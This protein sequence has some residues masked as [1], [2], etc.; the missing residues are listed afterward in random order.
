MATE[1]KDTIRFPINLIFTML[2]CLKS[3]RNVKALLAPFLSAFTSLLQTK[4]MNKPMFCPALLMSVTEETG[5]RSNC[6][7]N[8]DTNSNTALRRRRVVVDGHTKHSTLTP[9]A[10]AS[11]SSL[12][13]LKH[14]FD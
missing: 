4:L 10:A 11:P 3:P 1:K 8:S 12:L 14:I 13:F 9:V 5:K 6:L 2:L 7:C